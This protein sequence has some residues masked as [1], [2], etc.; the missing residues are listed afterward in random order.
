MQMMKTKV[1]KTETL[2]R[3][4]KKLHTM[5][6]YAQ[7]SCK[8]I[9][10]HAGRLANLMPTD[11]QKNACQEMI[12][13]INDWCNSMKILDSTM[14]ATEAMY[15]K[16]LSS[17]GKSCE[18]IEAVPVCPKGF[19]PNTFQMTE[20]FYRVGYYVIEGDPFKTGQREYTATDILKDIQ[21]LDTNVIFCLKAL[22]HANYQGIW[23]STGLLVNRLY[24]FEPTAYI[25]KLVKSYNVDMT[26]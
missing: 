11:E 13:S 3:R 1:I 19:V 7:E 10:F 26:D 22:I 12:A 15:S 2:E 5:A 16:H 18:V 8:A 25:Y 17:D 4:I 23:K 14:K 20:I 21:E 6:E 24:D 9:V